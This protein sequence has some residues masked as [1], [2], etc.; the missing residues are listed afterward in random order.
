M[1]VRNSCVMLSTW[2]ADPLGSPCRWVNCLSAQLQHVLGVPSKTTGVSVVHHIRNNFGPTP[3]PLVDALKIVFRGP[4]VMCH[5][6][7]T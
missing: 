1:A 2:L 7:P 3:C 6:L 5:R 4:T